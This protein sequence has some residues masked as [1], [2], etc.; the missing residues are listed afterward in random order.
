MDPVKIAKA[1]IVTSG[2]FGANVSHV[3]DVEIVIKPYA[4]YPRALSIT[5][6]EKGARK[7]KGLVFYNADRLPVLF[8]GWHDIPTCKV[9]E[10]QADGSSITRH[11][12]FSPE[13]AKETHEACEAFEKSHPDIKIYRFTL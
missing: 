2:V 10:R 8:E 12:S 13:I 3:R 1:T 7:R 6:A 11:S 5:F 9:S 4:Q